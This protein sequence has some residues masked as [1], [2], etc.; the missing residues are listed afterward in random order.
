MLIDTTVPK[1]PELPLDIDSHVA[2]GTYCNI[3]VVASSRWE[4]VI[5]FAFVGPGQPSGIVVS[6]IILHPEQAQAL[7]Q[8][9]GTKLAQLAPPA[10]PPPSPAG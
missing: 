1:H 9:L 10:A 2:R 5:D 3:A 7:H 6:R 4:V 8:A